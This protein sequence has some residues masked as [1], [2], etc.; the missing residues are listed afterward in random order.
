MPFHSSVRRLAIA[1][2]LL[3]SAACAAGGRS[4]A[5]APGTSGASAG[6]ERLYVTNQGQASVSI[7]DPASGMVVETVDLQQLGFSANAKPHHVVVEPDGSFWYVS[8]V[9]EN[10]VLKM[11]RQNRIVGRAPFEAAGLMALDPRSQTLLV[12]RSMSAVNPPKRIGVIDRDDMEIDELEVFHPR[13][14]AMLFHPQ[15]GIAYSASMGVNQVSVIDAAAEQVQLV[16]LEGPHHSLMQFAISPDGRT[17]VLSAEMTGR[18]LFFDVTDPKR[19][20][21]SGELEVGPIPFDPVYTPDGRFLYVPLKGANEV[22]KIDA[23]SRTIV[24]R[25]AGVG[26]F[27]EPHAALI[28]ADGSRLYVSNNNVRV[29]HDMHAMHG[30]QATPA[31]AST[32]APGGA[33][34]VTVV[35][36]GTDT[37]VRTIPVGKNATGLGLASGR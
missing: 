31:P 3:A 2:A 35:D 34:W 1:G 36:T 16:D 33:G 26:L 22:V 20:V 13:P 21:P 14:H 19:P 8:L 15:A 17:L 10:T 9:G 24:G 5:S 27:A 18:I 32:P 25:I 29:S 4:A 11:D 23:A 28:S 6:A 30:G 12:G 7:I 37:V